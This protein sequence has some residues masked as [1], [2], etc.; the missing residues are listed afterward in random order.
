[1]VCPG[2]TRCLTSSSSW[3]SNSLHPSLR[4]TTGLAS[5]GWSAP[6]TQWDRHMDPQP[7]SL[8]WPCL[9]V[10][11]EDSTYRVWTYD[12]CSASTCCWTQRLA[13]CLGRQSTVCFGKFLSSEIIGN[14]DLNWSFPLSTDASSPLDRTNLLASYPTSLLSQD[15][16]ICSDPHLD[17]DD[18]PLLSL[19]SPLS[20]R[21]ASWKCG[22]KHIQQLVP[23][24]TTTLVLS[25]RF[26]VQIRFRSHSTRRWC[27]WSFESDRAEILAHSHYSFSLAEPRVW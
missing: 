15:H 2:W 25:I 6:S 16:Y 12:R 24:P 9:R 7:L 4:S 22:S 14:E 11:S 27:C 17:S 8:L 3:S 5:A 1:M 26:L 13:D 19:L 21:Q 10:T 20:A 18:T 23:K